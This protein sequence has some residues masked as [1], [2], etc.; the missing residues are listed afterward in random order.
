MLLAVPGESAGAS[1]SIFSAPSRPP[2]GK[3]SI[4]SAPSRPP[5]GKRSI[6][7]RDTGPL[8]CCFAGAW[9]CL[10]VLHSGPGCGSGFLG[11]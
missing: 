3:G 5:P 7:S 9:V 4:F 8:T 11:P 10:M 2:P 1:C 6:L